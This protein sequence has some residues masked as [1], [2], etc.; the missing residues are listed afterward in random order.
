MVKKVIKNPSVA[1]IIKH[2]VDLGVAIDDSLVQINEFVDY[3]KANL[4]VNGNKG[5]LGEDVTVSVNGSK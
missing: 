2:T 5:S 4:K 3:I 1:K